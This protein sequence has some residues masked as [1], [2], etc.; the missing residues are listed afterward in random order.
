MWI[1]LLFA[2]GV[3]LPLIILVDRTNEKEIPLSE[4]IPPIIGE[5]KNDRRRRI[6]ENYSDEDNKY[7][8]DAVYS[9]IAL[10]SL[11]IKRDGDIDPR[12]I[13]VANL[14]FLKHPRYDIIL[15]YS[16]QK[17]SRKCDELL[18]MYNAC[19]ELAHYKQYCKKILARGIYYEAALDL[20][21]ALSQ[22][23]YSS[24]GV[25][26]SEM[27]ILD[28]IAYGLGIMR[29]DWTVLKQKYSTYTEP[30]KTRRKK[31]TDKTDPDPHKEK[32]DS[33]QR[34]E[35]AN[36][37]SN[38]SKEKSQ[39]ERSKQQEQRQERK[40]KSTTYGYK[41]TQAYNQLGLLSTASE[42]EIKAAFRLLVK[43]YH[44]DHL[45]S[46][47][48]DMERKISADQFRQIMEAYDHIRLERGI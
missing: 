41:I 28:E 16:K 1:T 27:E 31:E 38:R 3:F 15:S 30:Q 7:N 34:H 35:N 10:F 25:I 33:S 6:F 29:E 18:K 2:I 37:K 12:E 43:K 5:K 39:E 32:N 9:V 17:P 20:L 22:V 24:D 11:I 36:E 45:P 47:A 48:T 46:D 44:P 13:K 23:A 8:D 21:T 42:Q 14:Y 4:P 26:G 19:P 40:K